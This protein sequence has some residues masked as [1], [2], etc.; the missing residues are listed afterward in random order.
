M[1]L[2]SV[3]NCRK[4]NIAYR[5]ELGRD[6]IGRVQRGVF[7]GCFWELPRFAVVKIGK[8]MVALIK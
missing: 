1:L 2:D 8:N 5:V 3:K 7:L 6:I 4:K